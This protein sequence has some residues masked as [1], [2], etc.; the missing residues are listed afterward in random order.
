MRGSGVGV[1]VNATPV[2]A[3]PS[4]G[5]HNSAHS[6]RELYDLGPLLLTSGQPLPELPH[7][8]LAHI[9]RGMWDRSGFIGPN[10]GGYPVVSLLAPLP[11]A[12]DVANLI[13][14]VTGRRSAAR[15]VYGSYWVGVSGRR[16]APWLNY[17]YDGASIYSPRKLEQARQLT[18]AEA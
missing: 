17:L 14:S 10:N 6:E 18:G 5:T 3:E 13:E 9:L 4:V 2:T 15:P 16:C 1:R 7:E 11:L 8:S 12:H